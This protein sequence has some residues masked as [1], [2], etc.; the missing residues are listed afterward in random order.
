MNEASAKTMAASASPPPALL[1]QRRHEHRDE[2]DPQDRQDVRQI[3]LEH[4]G[5]T[6]PCDPTRLTCLFS[7]SSG[8]CSNGV[9]HDAHRGHRPPAG[10]ARRPRDDAAHRARARSGR[11]GGRRA[12]RA[13]SWSRASGPTSCC[14]TA[15]ADGDGSPCAG[16]CARS[17]HAPRVVLYAAGDDPSL[18]VTA[19]VPGADGLV[20]QGAP[21]PRSSSR[22]SGSSPAAAPRCRRWTA[23]SS[24]PPPTASSRRTWR[25]WRCSSTA[26]SPPRSPA[27]LRL[28]RR[29]IGAAD[30]APAG[31]P[32]R[33]ARRARAP[34]D[35]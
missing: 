23:S 1:Q 9:G 2:Q 26:P 19:R 5:G 35:V 11:R 22:R 21:R 31:A 24:T 3:E 14:S 29:R 18:P 12:R 4:R 28:D 15:A 16:A 17:S 32:A 33:R 27:T 25:C 13:R 10:G 34:P 6:L 7:P 8:A 30:R 20:R